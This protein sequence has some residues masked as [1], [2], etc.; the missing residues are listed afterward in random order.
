MCIYVWENL[1]CE[2]LVS[3]EV[4][5]SFWELN[6]DYFICSV[7]SVM[8]S[9]RQ[10]TEDQSR[11]ISRQ[12]AKDALIMIQPSVRQ[13]AMDMQRGELLLWVQGGF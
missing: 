6:P 4:V 13:G 9:A 2:A 7:L 12:I 10:I 3:N 8:L 5:H 1:V 11:G